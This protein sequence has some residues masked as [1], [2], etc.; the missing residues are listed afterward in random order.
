MEDGTPVAAV[1]AA[2]GYNIGQV[3]VR[4][5]PAVV[6]TRYCN[7]HIARIG[8]IPAEGRYI[9][10]IE[11]TAGGSVHM[12]RTVVAPHMCHQVRTPV[13]RE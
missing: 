13:L 8:H 9:D 3:A 1:V 5:L 11:H 7:H 2:A 10:H 6:H 12:P 4:T